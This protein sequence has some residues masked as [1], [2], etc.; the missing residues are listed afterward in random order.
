MWCTACPAPA[1]RPRTCRRDTG[2]TWGWKRRRARRC[3]GQTCHSRGCRLPGGGGAARARGGGVRR[4]GGAAQSAARPRARV[5]AGA[6]ARAGLPAAL[7]PRAD[8]KPRGPRRVRGRSRQAVRPALGDELAM[9]GV[10]AEEPGLGATWPLGHGTQGWVG[11]R[12][13]PKVPVAQA[14]QVPLGPPWPSGHGVAAEVAR[15]WQEGQGFV[16]A[17]LSGTS[18]GPRGRGEGGACGDL[19]PRGIRSRGAMGTASTALHATGVVWPSLKK[20]WVR[21]E[22][23]QP[24]GPHR[25]LMS[26]QVEDVSSACWGRTAAVAGR[27]QRVRRQGDEGLP[28]CVAA[29]A[30]FAAQAGAGARPRFPRTCAPCPKPESH[31]P[32]MSTQKSLW[33]RHTA[34][35]RMARLP[36]VLWANATLRPGAVMFQAKALTALDS[37]V[38]STQ[39]GSVHGARARRGAKSLSRGTGPQVAGRPHQRG[40]G[41]GW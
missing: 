7:P 9:Q 3:R 41:A 27:G 1:C 12:P 30:C 14:A 5:S 8:S 22:N 28:M 18:R 39:E 29:A 37:A 23:W 13:F 35:R 32:G 33:S 24:L 17:G 19:S 10:H 38:V 36:L 25:L 4:E 15:R 40:A 26:L 2:H 16:R 31:A 11:K 20:P 21:M 34:L 6:R